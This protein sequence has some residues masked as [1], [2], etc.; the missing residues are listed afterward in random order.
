VSIKKNILIIA[1]SHLYKDPRII[2]Q[3]KAFK[4]DYNVYTIGFAPVNDD[5][6]N[7]LIKY[8]RNNLVLKLIRLLLSITRLL[9]AYSTIVQKQY[10][11]DSKVYNTD[12]EFILCNDVDSLPLGFKISKNII[13]I[14]ADLHEFS[15]REFENKFTWK[16]Y[17]QPYKYWL[18]KSFLSR[19]NYITVVCSGIA[20]EYEKLFNV[21]VDGIVTNATFYESNLLPNYPG[22]KIKLIHHGGAMPNRKLDNMVQMMRYLDDNYILYLMLVSNG[23]AQIEYL[24]SLKRTVNEYKLNVLFLEP[25]KTELIASTIN[26]F[27][28]G[29]FI[30]EPVGFNELY[31]LPNKFFEY[32]QSRLCLA[33]SPNPEMAKIISESKLGVLSDDFTPIKMAKVIANLN[34]DDIYYYKMNSHDNAFKYSAD[35]NIIFMKE[36]AIKIS[37]SKKTFS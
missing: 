19:A 7:L 37:N 18:C 31:A 33:I 6:P 16:L 1:F 23:E 10:I 34:R 22:E 8:K 21:S 2:R 28:I 24:E 35:N 9:S 5:I 26:K 14:W 15:P 29:I 20:K 32:I 27:D 25:V 3:V 17:F 11:I 36:M 4:D 12:F 13:P 30:L